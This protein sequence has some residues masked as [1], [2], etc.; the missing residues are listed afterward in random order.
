MYGEESLGTRSIPPDQLSALI[1]LLGVS[2]AEIT[3]FSALRSFYM[4][5]AYP[6]MLAGEWL[7]IL[8]A[9]ERLFGR[10]EA[11]AEQTAPCLDV[12]ETRMPRGE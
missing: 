5:G 6:L 3:A 7:A 1:L 12:S 11:D 2:Y 10:R 4:V 9:A 8:Y